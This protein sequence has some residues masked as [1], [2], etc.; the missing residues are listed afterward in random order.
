MKSEI[1]RKVNMDHVYGHVIEC[2]T[3][4]PTRIT[5]KKNRKQSNQSTRQCVKNSRQTESSWPVKSKVSEN[6]D[7]DL[8][9]V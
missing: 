5:S 6:S 7:T 1:L 2:K 8:K 9:K 4:K 3:N